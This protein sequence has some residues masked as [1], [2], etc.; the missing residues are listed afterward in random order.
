MEQ[1]T[2]PARIGDPPPRRVR[3]PAVLSYPYPY[4]A[5]LVLSNDP[6]NT[7]IADWRELD[8]VIWQDL[9]VPFADSLFFR[10][11]NRNIPLQVDLHGHPEILRAHPHDTIHTWGDF[12]FGGARGFEREDAL[13]FAAW[14]RELGFA[15]RV[16]VDHSMFPGNLL[17]I[18]RYGSIPEIKDASGHVYPNPLYSLDIIHDLGIRYIWDGTITGTMG[19][20]R[21]L[22]WLRYHIQR[23]GST[24]RG[25]ADHVKH[26]MGEVLGVGAGFRS[27]FQDNAA[28]RPHRFPDG[29]VL[30]VFQRYGTWQRADIH[31]FGQLLARP[32]LERLLNSGGI[33]IAYTHLGKRPV[34]HMND[35]EHIPAHTRQAL[36]AVMDLYRKRELMVSPLSTMLD[37]LVLRDHIRVDRAKKRITFQADGIAYQTV[38]NAD[39]AG[40]AFSFQLKD[41]LGDGWTFT[42]SSE[43]VHP[44]IERAA[45]RITTL[46]FP[47]P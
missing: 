37:H 4:K 1:R 45:E 10:S 34:A 28:Y 11:F 5:W 39:L 41:D 21:P 18:Q 40:H 35:P 30:Y 47:G 24:G 17:H 12:L 29:R 43:P 33:C 44:R 23:T 22:P 16:W 26:R 32:E 38:G 7:L 36:T 9:K 27:Q 25:L 2:G 31:G 20:D 42:G 3:D 46:T 14:A 6:D 15:P 8:R 19:Q 13:H